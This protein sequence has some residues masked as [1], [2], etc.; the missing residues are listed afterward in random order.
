TIDSLLLVGSV[1]TKEHI[2]GESDCD[3]VMI[4]KEKAGGENL[5]K[6]MEKISKVV[7][8]YLEDPLYSSLLDLEV[9]TKEE[10]PKDG[11]GTDYP[12]TRVLVAQRGKAL[13]GKNPFE[14]IKIKDEDIKAS[15]IYMAKMCLEDIKEIP[16]LEEVDDYDKLYLTVDAV[17]GCGCAYLYYHGETEFYRSSALIL[18]EDKYKDK[19]NINPV[20]TAHYLRLAA[21]TITTEKF[22][23]NALKFCKEVV[24]QLS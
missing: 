5:E 2:A 23:E 14:G 6:S 20:I 16:S 3:F 15:A 17:L 24:K 22:A 10:I 12:W 1:V 21:K 8:K 9:L 18:F 11:V 4:L 19:I 13:I 7:L